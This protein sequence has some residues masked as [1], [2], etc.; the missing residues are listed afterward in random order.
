VVAG[1]KLTFPQEGDQAPGI[2]PADIVFILKQKPH[3][4]FIREKNDLVYT[5]TI[6][7]REALCGVSLSITTLDGRGL[8]FEICNII[9]PDFVEV[10]FFFLSHSPSVL[11]TPPTH[12][13]TPPPPHTH[14]VSLQTVVGQGMPDQK[15]PAKKGNLL[16]KFKIEFPKKLTDSQKL[17]VAGALE[18]N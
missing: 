5:A 11:T 17:K 1:T 12:P 18:P 16:I 15:N 14:T 4:W 6:S 2:V 3:R 7:L 8:N 13:L 9:S 10:Q